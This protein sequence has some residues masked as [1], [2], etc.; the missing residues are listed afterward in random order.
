GPTCSEQ[1]MALTRPRA[2]VLNLAG[3]LKKSVAGVATLKPPKED[4][5]NFTLCLIPVRLPWSV[6]SA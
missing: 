4:G 6:I 5:G 3:F 1:I 2:T